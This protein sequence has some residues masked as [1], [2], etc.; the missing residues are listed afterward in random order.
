[1]TDSD[2]HNA[3]TAKHERNREQR[4]SEI[5]RWVEYVESTPAERWGEQLNQVVDS[6]LDAAR[7]AGLSTD[8]YERVEAAGREWAE[9]KR[10]Q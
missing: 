1:M 9:D 8:Q 10:E 7:D 4:L 3:L 6:Q 2:E 5:K